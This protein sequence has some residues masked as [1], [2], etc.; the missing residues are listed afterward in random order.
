MLWHELSDDDKS[1]YYLASRA[2]QNEMKGD[3]TEVEEDQT[4]HPQAWKEIK[5]ILNNM[6]SNVCMVVAT[7]CK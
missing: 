4:S 1:R 6:Q 7:V 5:R 3:M 2:S